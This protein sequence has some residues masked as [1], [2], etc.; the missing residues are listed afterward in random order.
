MV[1]V[2]EKFDINKFRRSLALSMNIN[3][4][5]M[6]S[7]IKTAAKIDFDSVTKALNETTKP[8]FKNMVVDLP[9]VSLKYNDIV[10]PKLS[11]F[12]QELP[13]MTV[14]Y[15]KISNFSL[16]VICLQFK[17]INMAIPGH[18]LSNYNI[19]EIVE[20]LKGC[21]KQKLI[22]S[23]KLNN[24]QK[25]FDDLEVIKRE[26]K[27]GP[28]I[29]KIINILSKD[30]NNFQFCLL[31]MITIMEKHFMSSF[32]LLKLSKSTEEINSKKNTLNNHTFNQYYGFGYSDNRNEEMI[33]D[34]LRNAINNFYKGHK[35]YMIE[36]G[37]HFNRHEYAHGAID[38]N[39]YT[40]DEFIRIVILV[41]SFSVF[42][43]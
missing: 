43:D 28:F 14:D 5:E 21:N 40:L 35:G 34:T 13:K 24:Y 39:D 11:D 22:N 41:S 30:I 6:I 26:T 19:K 31:P 33:Y 29:D 7:A 25:L 17:L 42:V 3:S 18:M 27:S 38:P 36:G 20:E 15:N 37:K 4:K 1:A 10:L 9:K 8:H 2:E 12:Y 23:Y 16:M 32:N